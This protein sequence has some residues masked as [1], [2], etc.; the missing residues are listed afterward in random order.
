MQRKEFGYVDA[1]L[2]IICGESY[3]IVDI[4]Y[5]KYIILTIKTYGTLGD[6]EGLDTQQKYKGS[7]GGV[8]TKWFNYHKVFDKNFHCH[9]QVDYNNNNIHYNIYVDMNWATK[10]WPDPFHAYFLVLTEVN[11]N[12]FWG[13]LVE[14]ANV[15]PELYFRHQL[16]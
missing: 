13:Y 3:H 14:G 7:V 11:K 9:N 5:P 6:L 16:V 1:L 2:N 8:V 4:K 10:Y 12:Y 15:N